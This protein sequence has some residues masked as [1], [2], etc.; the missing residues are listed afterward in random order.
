MAD[1]IVEKRKSIYI[2]CAKRLENSEYAGSPLYLRDLNEASQNDFAQTWARENRK[3]LISAMRNG[4]DI[5]VGV[6]V[7]S[8]GEEIV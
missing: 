4:K 6:F 8:G 5:Q 2:P 3:N 7:K 1:R